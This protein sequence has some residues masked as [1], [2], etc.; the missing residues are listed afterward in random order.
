VGLTFFKFSIDILLPLVS[1]ALCSLLFLFR[2]RNH[3]K[4]EQEVNYYKEDEKFL[5]TNVATRKIITTIK[6]KI[7]R[8]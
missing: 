4:A 3:V 2:Q 7:A 8:M 6:N 1:S 5:E